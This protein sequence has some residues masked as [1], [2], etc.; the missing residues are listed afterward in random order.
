MAWSS[1]IVKKDEPQPRYVHLIV[2]I[3]SYKY[4]YLVIYLLTYNQTLVAISW[5]KSNIL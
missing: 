2:F 3:A 1:L 4:S 5:D